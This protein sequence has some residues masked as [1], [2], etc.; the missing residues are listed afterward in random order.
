MEILEIGDIEYEIINN[1]ELVIDSP[2]YIGYQLGSMQEDAAGVS[3]KRASKIKRGDWHWEYL[4]V[5]D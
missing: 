1:A 5:F 4:D 3:L 2:H